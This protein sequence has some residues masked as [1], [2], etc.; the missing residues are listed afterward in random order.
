VGGGANLRAITELAKQELKLPVK[1]GIPQGVEG[2][3]ADVDSPIYASLVGLILGG[4]ESP[5]ETK[6]Y[7]YNSQPSLPKG[8]TKLLN[9][10]QKI[11]KLI[12]PD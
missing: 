5:E 9:P 6:S 11:I 2:S 3:I 10:L 1:I 8:S 7:E 12:I 4:F